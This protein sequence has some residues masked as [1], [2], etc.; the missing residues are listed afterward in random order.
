MTNDNDEG[1]VLIRAEGS[2]WLIEGERHMNAMLSNLEDFPR[3]VR[4]IN[5]ESR[6]EILAFLP[7]DA[8]L[9][10]LWAINPEIVARLERDGDLQEMT[11][12]APE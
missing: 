4:C 9:D 11:V 1:I 8:G 10:E 6:I 3:P 7:D 12:V 5:F 2:C